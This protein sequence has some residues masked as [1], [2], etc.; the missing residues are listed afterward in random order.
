MAICV[1][2]RIVTKNEVAAHCRECK[3]C[4]FELIYVRGLT[5]EN[6]DCPYA[7]IWLPEKKETAKK[8][9]PRMYKCYYYAKFNGDQREYYLEVEAGSSKEAKD[10]CWHLVHQATGRH[11][12]GITPMAT[13]K[14]PKGFTK[15]PE[16]GY[17]PVKI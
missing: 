10:R 17:P 3:K 11:A 13:D 16:K 5:E 12:F 1:D 4:Q 7:K 6:Q 15:C 8:S 14:L 2:E 9:G